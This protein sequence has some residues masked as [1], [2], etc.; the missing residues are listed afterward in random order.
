MVREKWQSRWNQEIENKLYKIKP[1]TVR[2]KSSFHKRRRYETILTRV[3]IGHSNFSHVHLMKREQ[4]PRCCGVPL[5]VKHALAC[6]DR[7]K[8]IRDAM[9]PQTREKTPDETMKILLAEG[10]EFDVEKLMEYLRR[11][12]IYTKI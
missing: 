6:C 4:Q 2:W 3:R 7:N 1:T 10:Q 11:I 12:D 5:T 9:Y 8:A